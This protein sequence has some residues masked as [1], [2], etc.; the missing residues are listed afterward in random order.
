MFCPRAPSS[1][2]TVN[3]NVCVR[4]YFGSH[5]DVLPHTNVC[6]ASAQENSE[7]FRYNLQE[8]RS[9]SSLSA[10]ANSVVKSMILFNIFPDLWRFRGKLNAPSLPDRDTNREYTQQTRRHPAIAA[11]RRLMHQ[12]QTH[13]SNLQQYLGL[14]KQAGKLGETLANFGEPG[15]AHETFRFSS[16]SHRFHCPLIRGRIMDVAV[17]LST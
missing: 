8:N 15:D 4:G 1:G 10:S 6:D 3:V 14:Y 2:D 9:H 17:S 5:S 7:S 13:K 16:K 12:I 11:R